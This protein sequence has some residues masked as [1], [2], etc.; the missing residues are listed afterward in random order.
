MGYEN[1]FGFQSIGTLEMRT[2]IL[3]YSG[4]IGPGATSQQFCGNTGFFV[5]KIPFLPS[6]SSFPQKKLDKKGQNW[7]CYSYICVDLNTLRTISTVD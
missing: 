5:V 3:L 2:W 4:E 6:L 7:I 1:T